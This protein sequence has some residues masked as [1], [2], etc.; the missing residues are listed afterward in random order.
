MCNIMFIIAIKYYGHF[1][2]DVYY[3]VIRLPVTAGRF[4]YTSYAWCIAASYLR[5]VWLA[6]WDLSNLQGPWM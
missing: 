2:I 6:V 4:V 3:T 1:K 5:C